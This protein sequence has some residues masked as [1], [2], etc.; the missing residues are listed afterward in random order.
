MYIDKRHVFTACCFSMFLFLL[1][2]AAVSAGAQSAVQALKI[3]VLEDI[4]SKAIKIRWDDPNEAKDVSIMVDD[5]PYFRRPILKQR[6]IGQS[7]SI[8]TLKEGMLPGIPYYVLIEPGTLRGTFRFGLHEWNNLLRGPDF[9]YREWD[10][11]GRPWLEQYAGVKWDR[12]NRS[13]RLVGERPLRE[14]WPI[15]SGQEGPNAYYTEYIMRGAVHIAFVD[16]HPAFMDELADFYLTYFKRFTTLGA[17]RSMESSIN[18]TDNLNRQGHDSTMTL[19][20]IRKGVWT[21]KGLLTNDIREGVSYNAQFFHPVSRLIRL[22]STLPESERSPKI[23]HFMAV[24]VPIVARDH[25]VRLGY[26]AYWRHWRANELPKT[27]VD[28]WQRIID[29][30]PPQKLSYWDRWMG[31]IWQKMMDTHPAKKPSYQ[32][33]MHD[34]DLWIIATAAE[35]LG[36]N[37]N[38]PDLVPLNERELAQLKKIVEVGVKLFKTKQ[39]IYQDT[40][41][42]EGKQVASASYF[43]GVYDDHAD[44]QYAGYQG[45]AFPTLADKKAP[46]GGSWDISHFYQVPVLMRSL[47]DNK[48]ATGLTYPD[49][50]DIQQLINQYLYRVFHGDF[51]RPLF[52]NFFDGNDGWYKVGQNAGHPPSQQCDEQV[53]DRPCMALGAAYG[54]GLL[55]S[56]NDDLMKLQ[57]A[58]ITLAISHDKEVKAFRDRYYYYNGQRFELVGNDGSMKYPISLF[59]IFSAVAE[60]M[61]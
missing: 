17:L 28:I 61:L 49:A 31:D 11:S 27:L 14:E 21:Q 32:Y 15:P 45:T 47:Y 26:I 44:M 41:D 58:Y 3:D 4:K 33:G 40:R 50:M 51:N 43:S 2:N 35:M 7:L 59:F 16:H 39:T 30:P 1:C 22:F 57:R 53:K 9:L 48:N 6:V 10:V 12:V 36:A 13:W 38:N 46:K 18:S 25:L 56:F 34:W 23:R 19:P 5:D 37:A 60:K 52:R 42:F 20:W 29:T 54:W 55:A 8:D 24:Y